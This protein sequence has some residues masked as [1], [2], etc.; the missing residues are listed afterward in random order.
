M[1][2]QAADNFTDFRDVDDDPVFVKRRR[3]FSVEGIARSVRNF[4]TLSEALRML[5]A[6][7]LVASMS[8]FLL[9]G[10]SEGNDIG[11]Y[12]M[13]L[14]Q[15]VL[16]AAAGFAMSHGLRETR[17][18]RIFFGLSLVS[19][20]ANFTI[21]GAMV[22]SVFSWDIAPI[23][24]PDYALW[25][26]DSFAGAGV[27]FAG[28]MLVLV[29]VALFCFAILARQSAKTLSLHF[30]LL[31]SLLL[32]PIRGSIAVGTVALAGVLYALLVI[33][34]L[35]AKDRSLK[36]A[37]GKFALATLFIPVG[38][39]LFRSMYFYQVDSLMIAVISM[40]AFL[41]ARQVSL[42][43]DRSARVAALLEGLSVPIALVASMSLA[44]ALRPVLTSALAGPA[45]STIFALLALDI[46]RRTDS[47]TLASIIT[48]TVS[49]AVAVGFLL[50]VSSQPGPLTALLCIAAG[51][52]LLLAGVS[53]HSRIASMFG[54]LTLIGG[55][56]FGFQEI[57]DLIF[58]SSW[59][60]L[61]VFGACAIA[62]GSV[63]D[64]HGVVI[65]LRLV[66]WFDEI[67][68]QRA[69]IAVEN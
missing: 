7:V 4:A 53:I 24:V 64:R 46:L 33:G 66:K 37:E 9:Q 32:L 25:Q 34:K 59:V 28:A 52:T 39:I 18:A 69:Q 22:Y 21:L 40:S 47:S 19:I 38:I 48:M 17:G 3:S 10:W 5:G 44:D 13:L 57:L 26:I 27:T 42:F 35:S 45:F 8:V 14:T 6:A 12:L 56:V 20:P 2:T 16:L 50:G 61:A 62:L 49:V 30:L 29:P 43:P 54:V 55:A 23:D 31:N 60:E 1:N 41:A 67:G 36:T 15:T 63:I 68:E 58:T 51:A 65:K 11:R